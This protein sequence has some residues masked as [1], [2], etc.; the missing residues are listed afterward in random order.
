MWLKMA[1]AGIA[2]IRRRWRKQCKPGLDVFQTFN[3]VGLQVT[4][5]T[6]GV[7][8]P[9]I[10]LSPLRGD[11]Y[12]AGRAASTNNEKPPNDPDVSA[13]ARQPLDQAAIAWTTLRTTKRKSELEAFIKKYGDSFYGDLARARLKELEADEQ[14][15][16]QPRNQSD[17]RLKTKK[18]L[19]RSSL[20]QASAG[21][22]KMVAGCI[23]T[24]A[25]ALRHAG[26]SDLVST[27]SGSCRTNPSL[28]VCP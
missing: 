22:P 27:C 1:M 24:C 23:Q 10:S 5:T 21:C 16:E 12:F 13:T 15:H 26:R 9:W 20:R 17:N 3:Q 14:S 4:A 11:F 18:T 25:N 7:Q 8:Q 28:Q 2:R 6:G 19:E